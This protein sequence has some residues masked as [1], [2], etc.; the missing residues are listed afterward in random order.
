MYFLAFLVARVYVKERRSYDSQ[1]STEVCN[2]K[3]VYFHGS[4][5][6]FH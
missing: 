2:R 5:I 6:T 4:Y 3:D 1:W